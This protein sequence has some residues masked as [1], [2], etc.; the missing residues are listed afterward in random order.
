MN[1]ATFFL[2][3]ILC[4]CFCFPLLTHLD[5]LGRGDWDYFYFNHEVPQI[6]IFS[7]RQ[8]PF[9]N[10]FVC[11]GMPLLGNPQARFLSPSILITGL[12]GVVRGL[13]I[14]IVLHF[15]L[16]MLGMFWLSDQMKIRGLFRLLPGII[17]LF[18]GPMVLHLTE[19]HLTWLPAVYLPFVFLFFLKAAAAPKKI[20]YAALFLALMIYEGGTYVVYF[21]LLFLGTFAGLSSLQKRSWLPFRNFL[22]LAFFGFLFSAPKSVPEIDLMLRHPRPDKYF[23]SF[24]LSVRALPEIFISTGHDMFKSSPLTPSGGW[25]EYGAYIGLLVAILYLLSFAFFLKYVPLL[26]SS[27]FLLGIGLGNFSA[28]A[29][30]TILHHLPFFNNMQVPSRV[31]IVFVFTVGLVVASFLQALNDLRRPKKDFQLLGM[32]IMIFITVDLFSVN[33]KIFRSAVPP[34]YAKRELV[35]SFFQPR[36]CQRPPFRQYLMPK[37]EQIHYFAWSA[38]HPALMENMGVVNG[39]E[40]VPLPRN[41]VGENQ[42]GYRGEYYL[43]R[44]HGQ[45]RQVFWSPNKLIFDMDIKSPDRLIINQNYDPGWRVSSRRAVVPEAGLISTEVSPGL[46]RITFDYFPLS[47]LWGIGAMFFGAVLFFYLAPIL[48]KGRYE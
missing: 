28:W 36:P 47:F 14:E 21:S 39:Y 48:D 45:V 33:S 37:V 20:V 16:G 30:W 19:G 9:W 31:F 1:R 17:F 18:S 12:F 11:G 29:P 22:V 6:S 25:W 10:P 3:V 42:T 40:P 24:A 23:L 34:F 26:L 5:N 44:G 13:K 41:A 15:I 27:L 7:F 32:F 43:L 38:M 8:F 4:L 2:I 46:H 35:V